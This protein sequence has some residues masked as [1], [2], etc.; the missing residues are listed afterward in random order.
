MVQSERETLKKLKPDFK[1]LMK[2]NGIRFPDSS[3]KTFDSTLSQFEKY[4]N[5]SDFERILLHEYY[6]EK[7]K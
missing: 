2:G 1:S 7:L 6:L 5:F 3:F 4:Q